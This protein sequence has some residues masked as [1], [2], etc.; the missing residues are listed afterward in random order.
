M[1]ES[2]TTKLA[3]RHSELES[4]SHSLY[5]VVQGI[6]DLTHYSTTRVGFRIKIPTE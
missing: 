6:Q 2:T 1:M 4:E 3:S 5:S